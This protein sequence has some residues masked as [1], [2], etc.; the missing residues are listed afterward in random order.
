LKVGRASSR[1][2]KRDRVHDELRY[3][4]KLVRVTH[5]R[6]DRA[7]RRWEARGWELEDLTP[8]KFRTN[9]SFRRVQPKPNWALRIAASAIALALVAGLVIAG[10]RILPNTLFADVQAR[11]DAQAAMK[12]LRSGDLPALEKQLAANRGGSAFAYYFTRQATPRDL[13][14]A[15]S[16]VASAEGNATLT[17]GTDPHAYDIELTDLAGTL[18]L[19]T[20]GTGDRALPS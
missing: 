12:A 15:L 13:G 4:R 18:A 10:V 11:S 7:Q 14:D 16:T 6:R 19:A 5:R 8:G 17:S 20:H 2:R 3:R 9:L 1:R